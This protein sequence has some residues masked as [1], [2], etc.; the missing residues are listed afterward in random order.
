MLHRVVSWGVCEA[1]EAASPALLGTTGV[2]RE[3]PL[4]RDTT[5]GGAITWDVDGRLRRYAARAMLMYG[6]WTQK[7]RQVVPCK[8]KGWVS[9]WSM[10]RKLSMYSATW[11]GWIRNSPVKQCGLGEAAPGAKCLSPSPRHLLSRWSHIGV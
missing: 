11:R 4:R 8:A 3:E 7:K 10:K 2:Q 6:H 9:V 5:R 1:S